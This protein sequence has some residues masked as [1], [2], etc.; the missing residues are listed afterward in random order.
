MEVIVQDKR[1]LY[2]I[3]ASHLARELESWLEL[4]PNEKRDWELA[5]YLHTYEKES[6]LKNHP[7]DYSILGKWEDF[8]LTKDDYC[9]ISVSD[10]GWKEKIFLYLKDKTTFFTY[11]APNVIIGKFNKICEGSFICPNSVISTNV[12]IGRSVFLNCGTQVGHDV[13]IGNFTSVMANVDIGGHCKIGEKV[14]IGSNAVIIPK[15]T[16]EDNAR[17]GAGSVVIKKV[18]AGTTVFG[19]PAKI[20]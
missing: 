13:S 2:I 17:I 18:K 11:I 19:N 15:I 5:G 3:G 4:I 10:S 12:N 14:F 16:V 9:I 6:P 1:K 7:T 20:I 8:S